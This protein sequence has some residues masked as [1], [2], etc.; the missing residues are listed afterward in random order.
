MLYAVLWNLCRGIEGSGNQALS[1]F[2]VI[3]V[4]VHFCTP[5]VDFP[6][7]ISLYSISLV[8]SVFLYGDMAFF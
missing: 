3:F 2:L 7:L 8:L 6:L 4:A 5:A 1:T